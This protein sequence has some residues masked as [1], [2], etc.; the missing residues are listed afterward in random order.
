MTVENMFEDMKERAQIERV[1]WAG[2]LIWAGLVFG[3]DVLGALPVIGS[4]DAWSW[5]FLGAGLFGM[6]GT[7]YRSISPDILDPTGWDYIWSGFWLL[8]GLSGF[9]TTNLIWPLALVVIGVIALIGV[10]RRS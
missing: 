3:A 8:V 5:V 10:F 2:V 6:L 9:V 4:A 1:Y 7:G